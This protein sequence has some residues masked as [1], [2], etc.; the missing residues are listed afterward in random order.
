M[1]QGAADEGYGRVADEFRRNFAERGEVGAACRRLPDGEGRRPVGRLPRRARRRAV[2][3]RT[4]SS[5]VFSTTKGLARWRS[6]SPTRRGLARLD[7]PVAAYWPEFGRG[8]DG[9]TV[10][11]CSPPGRAAGD[12]RA[13]RPRRP[14]RPRRRPRRS[15]RRRPPWEPGTRHGYHGVTLGWYEGELIRRVDPSAARWGASSPRRSRRR[16]GSSSTSACRTT[17]DQDRMA[18][19]HGSKP[20]EMLLHLHDPATL[21][22][23]FLNP[24][25]LT[26]RSFANPVWSWPTVYNLPEMRRAGAPGRERDGRRRVPSP[27]PTATRDRRHGSA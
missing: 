3:R 24:R 15:P 1:V 2:A 16:S 4:R 22:A 6:P 13:A 11:S 25:S 18:C 26:A 7:E 12:R 20:A 8:K 5:R 9:V 19:I 10:A 17:S 21:R 23:G 27:A 14:R